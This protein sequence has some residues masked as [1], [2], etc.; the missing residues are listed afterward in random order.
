MKLKKIM[1][2][3]LVSAMCFSVG[4]TNNT[5]TNADKKIQMK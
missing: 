3:A 1:A 5:K 4:C 2:F